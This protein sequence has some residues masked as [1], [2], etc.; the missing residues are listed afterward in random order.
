M[1][2]GNIKLAEDKKRFPANT[3]MEV[4]TFLND[5]KINGELYAYLQTLS[6]YEVIDKDNNLFKT[7]VL[8]KSLPS[9]SQICKTLGIKSPKTYKS[10]LSYL[11]EQGYVIEEED[12]YML[13]EMENIYFLIP[14]KTL[15][16]INDNCK[17]HI[18]K[19]YVYLGQ[20]YKWALER[21]IQYEFTL[22][23]LG[24]HS[25]IKVENNTRGYEI[26]NNALTFLCNS[27]LIDY[28]SFFDGKSQKKR[29]TKFCFDYKDLVR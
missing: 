20:R 22:K 14:L 17:E 7:F 13:P 18:I 28:V 15:Q 4:L 19:I 23:E 9:Q 10:H 3:T 27:E 24:E 5:K 8:K 1:K 29:L 25:G 16:Y 12:R 21:G 2:G 6:T 26:V 11:I